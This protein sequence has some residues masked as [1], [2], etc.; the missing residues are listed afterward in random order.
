MCVPIKRALYK[1]DIQRTTNCT[2][3]ITKAEA[4]L[5]FD[6][7]AKRVLEESERKSEGKSRSC[8]NLE[9]LPSSNRDSILPFS[10][11][12]I[13]TQRAVCER[14]TSRPQRLSSMRME[15]NVNL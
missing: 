11:Q 2:C 5:R 12:V 15:W 13:Q 14:M 6:F 7:P 8:S 4:T 9:M 10:T 1:S 3:R